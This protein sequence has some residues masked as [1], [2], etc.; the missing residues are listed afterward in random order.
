MQLFFFLI[1]G[2]SGCFK[3]L[4]SFQSSK[5]VDYDSFASVFVAFVEGELLEFLILPFLLI[6][7]FLF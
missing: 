3:L 6:L 5:R 2:F 7:L 4:A 1:K